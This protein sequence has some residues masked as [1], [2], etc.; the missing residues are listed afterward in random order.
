[1]VTNLPGQYA[2]N[3]VLARMDFA[4]VYVNVNDFKIVTFIDSFL[5]GNGFCFGVRG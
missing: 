1:M 4:D 3:I 2:Q 5:C